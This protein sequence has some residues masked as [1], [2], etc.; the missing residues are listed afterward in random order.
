VKIPA[1]FRIRLL[2]VVALLALAAPA[3]LVLAVVN[4]GQGLAEQGGGEVVIRGDGAAEFRTDPEHP[5]AACAFE[6]R[7]EPRPTASGPFVCT[8]SDDAIALGIPFV[9]VHGTVTAFASES[10]T[11]ATLSGTA[12]LGLPD[13]SSL[14]DVAFEADTVE[15]GVDAGQLTISIPGMFDGEAGD[16]SVGDGDYE[17]WP[18]TLTAGD[19]SVDIPSPSP[20]PSASSS[21]S[22]SP[23]PTPSASSSATPSPTPTATG[24]PSPTPTA[25]VT[26]SPLPTPTFSYSPYPLPSATVYPTPPPTGSIYVPTDTGVHSTARLMSILGSLEISGTPSLAD[27]L[28][29]VGPFPVAGL[30]W[31]QDDWHAYRCCPYPHLHQGLDM[32]AA[33]GTPVVAAANGFISQKVVNS[34]SG[35]GLEI[36]AP[37]GVQYFYAHLSAFAVG[38]ELGTTVTTGEIIGYVGNTGNAAETSPHLHFEVQPN[39]I[40]V[41]P[42]PYVDGWLALAEQKATGLFLQRTG[43][44]TL[45]VTDL[46][47]WQALVAALSSQGQPTG[48]AGELGQ[49]PQTKP[50]VVRRK[51]PAA[52]PGPPAGAMI[53]VTSAMLLALLAVPGLSGRRR[54]P[55]RAKG[56]VRAAAA[57][58]NGHGG[59]P[60]GRP[61]PVRPSATRRAVLPATSYASRATG[62]PSPS[63][64]RPST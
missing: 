42:I 35:L 11:E 33:T 54:R 7:I 57:R 28:S 49:D 50:A 16:T 26:P 19:I 5:V 47:R 60:N 45:Q 15:G 18:Q 13:G 56:S 34:I 6:F 1:R 23:S 24:T 62:T 39:G 52:D 31:W 36:T 51:P 32:F 40:P 61:A 53:L 64:G 44:A 2:S 30:S 37:D 17:Q 38:I 22:E 14:E 46:S 55:A 25:T 48:A 9:S 3:V 41:P 8:Y 27:V 63:T 4:S 58:T 21:S 12:T 10:E 20:S 59:H 43:R 29:V